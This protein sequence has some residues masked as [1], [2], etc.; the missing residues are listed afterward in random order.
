M[1]RIP[2]GCPFEM[3][4]AKSEAFLRALCSL[5]PERVV[6]ISCNPETLSRDLHFLR[7]H[8]R[9]KAIQPVD[10]FPH[11]QHVE[12]VCLLSKLRAEHHIEVDLDLGEMDLNSAESKAT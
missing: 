5:G 3:A 4:A 2:S 6:Y 9:V 10:M 12:T 7:P 1:E 11:T 8:Y